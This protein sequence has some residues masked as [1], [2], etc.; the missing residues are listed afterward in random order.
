MDTQKMLDAAIG[1][2]MRLP[3]CE[4]G[5]QHYGAEIC[6]GCDCDQQ[7]PIKRERMIEWIETLARSDK[8]KEAHGK[9]LR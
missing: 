1:V 3:W 4:C 2:L 7:V 9:N 5:H 6:M 8:S